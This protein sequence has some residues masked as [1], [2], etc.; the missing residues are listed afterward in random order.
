MNAGV[1]ILVILITLLNLYTYVI[2]AG[3]LISW[4]FL[5]PTNPVIRFLRFLTEP[6]LS[7]CRK[8]LYR[9]LPSTWRRIDFSPVL[10]LLLVQLVIY[11]LK[12]V[13]RLS[14]GV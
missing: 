3:A 2:L 1:Y 4:F 9:I 14:S 8:L 7:P 13:V 6:V 10:A 5:P 12:W 11:I